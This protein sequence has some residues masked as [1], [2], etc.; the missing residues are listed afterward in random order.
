MAP[1][2]VSSAAEL[3][4]LARKWRAGQRAFND[5]FDVLPSAEGQVYNK[6]Y[7]KETAD[8]YYKEALKEL[9]EEWVKQ[10]TRRLT[11]A[12][13]RTLQ[14]ARRQAEFPKE[15]LK[16]MRRRLAGK[17]SILEQQLTERS[18]LLSGINDAKKASDAAKAKAY[19][20]LYLGEYISTFPKE[21]AWQVA[22]S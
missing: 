10:E 8:P 1:S 9:N 11:A 20:V 6:I 4:E 22:T 2:F 18:G 15:E 16:T 17:R 7:L 13:N 14:Q 12:D 3:R 5:L 19:L 21:E